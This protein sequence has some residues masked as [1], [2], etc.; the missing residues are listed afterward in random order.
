[1]YK[2][3]EVLTL[4]KEMGV[5]EGKIMEITSRMYT[6]MIAGGDFAPRQL[7][8]VLGDDDLL[9]SFREAW[10]S[11]KLLHTVPSP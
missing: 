9:A 10:S 7:G 4:L 11:G 1:M 5:S 6:V 3:N 2:K 8:F